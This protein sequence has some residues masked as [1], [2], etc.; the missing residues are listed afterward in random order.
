VRVVH[1]ITRLIVGGAQENT[2]QT[3]ADQHHLFADD[4]SLITGPPLGPEGSLMDRAQRDTFPVFL[5]PELRRSVHPWRD[6]KSYRSLIRLLR[7]IQPDIVHTHSSKAGILGRAAAA[8]LGIPAVHT[9]HGASF[10]YGQHPVLFRAYVLAERWAALRT[11]HFI[12]VA[13]AMTSAYVGQRIDR[14]ERFTTICSGFDVEPF[15]SPPRDPAVVRAQWGLTPEHFVIGKVA[16]LFHLKGHEFLLQAAPAIVAAHPQARFLLVGNGILREPLH[17]QIDKLGLADHFIFTGLVPPEEIPE[18]IHAMD[19]V[20][21]TSQWEGLARVLPQASIAGKPVVTYDVGGAREV[22][23]PGE[24]GYVLPRDT[25]SELAEAVCMLANDA[26]LRK[27]LGA[28]GREL[29]TDQFRHQTMTRRIREV[30]GAVL[31]QRARCLDA[32]GVSVPN[33]KS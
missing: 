16:R 31:N 3:V 1:V 32:A 5:V 6:W 28:R 22:V 17:R 23:I 14:P 26:E 2:L 20:V 10:H 18:L 11:A 7:E 19:V 12:S 25:V 24:T 15:L 21:H 8:A 30:Y 27:R 33:P 29:L 13:D 4:V 9:V